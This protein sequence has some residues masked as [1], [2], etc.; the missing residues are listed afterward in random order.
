MA[1]EDLGRG[2]PGWLTLLAQDREG[3]ANL[4]RL[5]TVAHGGDVPAAAAAQ[6]GGLAPARRGKAAVRVPLRTL[7]ERARG[8]FALHAGAD[9]EEAAR[10]RELFGRRLAITVARHHV[11]GEEARLAAARAVGGRLRIPVAV[12]NDVH[13]HTRRRQVLQDVLTCVRLGATVEKAGR[14]L[15][16]GSYVGEDA[17]QIVLFWKLLLTGQIKR[18]CWQRRIGGRRKPYG[19]LISHPTISW[20]SQNSQ[21]MSTCRLHRMNQSFRRERFRLTAM[22]NCMAWPAGSIRC[23]ALG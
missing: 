21:R 3:Y 6:P 2:R 22:A 13:T 9:A 7:G 1:V 18:Q 19:L 14:R 16:R 5:L 11:A 17:H 10:L 12:V 4:C 15:F 8:L 23:C 20:V